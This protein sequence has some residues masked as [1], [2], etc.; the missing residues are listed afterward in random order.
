MGGVEK[1]A[2]YPQAN[3]DGGEE[4]GTSSSLAR[5]G[6]VAI[7]VIGT[8]LEVIENGARWNRE[9]FCHQSEGLIATYLNRNSLAKRG[10]ASKL[11]RRLSGRLVTNGLTP[12]VY[13]S[14]VL[15]M[16]LGMLERPGQSASGRAECGGTIKCVVRLMEI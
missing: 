3:G 16:H 15:L 5:R 9:E 2:E 4:P 6:V 13:F 12:C 1:A 14:L 10:S 11:G 7:V 8:E